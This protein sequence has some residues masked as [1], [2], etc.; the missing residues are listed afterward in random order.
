MQGYIYLTRFFAGQRVNNKGVTLYLKYL[1]KD[2]GLNYLKKDGKID[3]IPHSKVEDRN[4]GTRSHQFNEMSDR[5][6]GEVDTSRKY[7]ISQ[8]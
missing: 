6:A 2:F 1:K 4:I 7:Q 5:I 8:L 3:K